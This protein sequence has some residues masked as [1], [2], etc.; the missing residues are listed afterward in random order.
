[1]TLRVTLTAAWMSSGVKVYRKCAGHCRDDVR[2]IHVPVMPSMEAAGKE[3]A[4][5]VLAEGSDRPECRC[6]LW[7]D[8]D[9]HCCRV[10]TLTDVGMKV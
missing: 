4:T 3:G 8:P 1:V 5:G 2:R 7:N 9:Y 10:G 6:D